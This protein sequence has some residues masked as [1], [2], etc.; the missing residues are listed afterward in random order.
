MST[1]STA[2]AVILLGPQGR[3]PI[4]DAPAGAPAWR[5]VRMDRPLSADRP[6]A[7]RVAFLAAHAALWQD[8]PQVMAWDDDIEIQAVAVAECLRLMRQHGLS[9][10]QPGLA[11]NSHFADATT[12]HN[13]CFV[14]RHTSR[15]DSAV[16]AFGTAALRRLLPLMQA[17]PSRNALAR[18]L[19]ACQDVPQAGAAVLDAVQAL[20]TSAPAD[21]EFA[22]PDWPAVLAEDGPQH[23]AAL[24][25]GGLGLRG[26]RVA[27]FDDSRETFLGLLAAGYACAVA[28]PL[29]IGEVFLQHFTRSLAP[30]PAALDL[31]APDQRGS[32]P[33]LRRSPIIDHRRAPSA[34]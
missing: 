20:R 18:L 6:W 9:L 10:C 4:G 28:E 17:M 32:A 7:E 3:E 25:W 5:I 11:W 29:P 30:P 14:Y 16:L 33:T 26:Q 31:R 22:E 24:S 15:L 27:L 2:P 19:P 23:E 1:S 8:A 34:V 13:P 21:E 12:L